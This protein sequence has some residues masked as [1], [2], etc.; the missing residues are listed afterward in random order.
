MNRFNR[1][2]FLEWLALAGTAPGLSPAV[3]SCTGEQAGKTNVSPVPEDFTLSASDRRGI[4]I[5]RDFI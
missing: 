2:N 1:R 5:L 3:F 4:Q